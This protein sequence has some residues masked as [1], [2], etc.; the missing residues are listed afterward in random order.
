MKKNI[1]SII[2]IILGAFALV[3]L[4]PKTLPKEIDLLIC[5]VGIGMAVTSIIRKEDRI[6]SIS[7]MF[8]SV[9]WLFME[10]FEALSSSIDWA[11]TTISNSID[12]AAQALTK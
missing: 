9:S 7:G 8:L 1:F 12:F 3:H 4:H 10:R 6:L 2:A 11:A 5:F